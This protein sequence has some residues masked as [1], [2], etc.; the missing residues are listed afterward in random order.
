MRLSSNDVAALGPAI[1]AE[2][3][4]AHFAYL[5]DLHIHLLR[6]QT[7]GLFATDNWRL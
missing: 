7:Y 6:E 4:T 1:T 2:R 5:S 3:R